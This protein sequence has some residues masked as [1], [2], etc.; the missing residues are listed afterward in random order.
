MIMREVAM[1]MLEM[2][3]KAVMVMILINVDINGGRRWRRWCDES[4]DYDGR[5]T[6]KM[7]L[8]EKVIIVMMMTATIMILGNDDFV[9][10]RLFLCIDNSGENNESKSW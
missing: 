7:M 1:I 5:G 10:S 2:M 9:A 3:M 4:Q 8:V 6:E